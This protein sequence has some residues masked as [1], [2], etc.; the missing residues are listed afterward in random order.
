MRDLM[1]GLKVSFEEKTVQI[2][3]TGKRERKGD[4]RNESGNGKTVFKTAKRQ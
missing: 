2:F 3:S 4:Y 1:A